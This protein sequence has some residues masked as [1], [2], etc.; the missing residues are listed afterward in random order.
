MERRR[1]TLYRLG[2]LTV[3]VV[4]LLAI[5]SFVH[6]PYYLDLLIA[7]IVRAVLGMVFVLLLR[8]GMINMGIAAFW[9]IGAYAS[10]IMVMNLHIPF[11]GALWLSS[12]ATALVAFGIGWILVGS[13][14]SGFG[15][16]VLSA[17]I[18]QMFSVVMGSISYV[19]GYSGRRNVP[20]PEAISLPGGHTIA[21]GVSNK[22]SYYYLAL[23]LLG[24]IALVL[25]T[26]YR[27]RV[28][29]AWTAIGL[30]RRLAESLGVNAFRYR[31]AVFVVGSAIAGLIGSFYAHYQGFVAPDSFGMWQNIY[32]QIYAILGGIGFP[33]VG[34]LVGAGLM[35][36][37]P[38]VSRGAVVYA[39]VIMG[40]LLV[41]L[42]LFLPQGILGIGRWRGQLWTIGRR[43]VR[44]PGAGSTPSAPT[45]AASVAAEG[46]QPAGVTLRSE[47]R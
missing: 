43:I 45:P 2:L 20:G 40:F 16:V 3:V 44:R 37:L 18:G 33:I 42:V 13:G 6:S 17:V 39:P 22:P 11:W 9:G 24:I 41:L 21:F 23:L 27:S 36:M 29:R 12:V 5:P 26:L 19:G 34:S 47:E 38:E 7:L 32:F 28:G 30:N 4:F 25:F 46:G 35:T 1:K 31:L 10:V 14:S 15:F 8:A